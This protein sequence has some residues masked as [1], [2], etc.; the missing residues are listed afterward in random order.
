[1]QDSKMNRGEL[2]L[3]CG[4]TMKQTVKNPTATHLHMKQHLFSWI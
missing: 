3:I 2:Y 4:T 1:M